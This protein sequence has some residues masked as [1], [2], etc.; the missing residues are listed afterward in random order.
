[1]DA[2]RTWL[3][4]LTPWIER[5]VAAEQ[6]SE[7]A[8][9][10]LGRLRGVAA[11]LEQQLTD[12]R[13]D[14]AAADSEIARLRQE[15]HEISDQRRGATLA[16]QHEGSQ[17]RGSMAGFLEDDVLALLAAVREG[18]ELD[19]PRVPFALE[20]LEDAEHAIETKARWLRSSD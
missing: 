11:D 16:R 3:D 20:R 6:R 5:A 13:R 1:M 7:E 19:R 10:D 9:A 17:F 14:N 2:I 4:L 18:L 12:A 8:V 15:I